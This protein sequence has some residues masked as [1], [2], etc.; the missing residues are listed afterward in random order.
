MKIK[1]IEYENFRNFKDYG[2]IDC[3]VDG[4]ITIIY[5]KNGDGKTT[6][7]QLMK[8]VFYGTVSF[9]R[10]TTDKLYNH[11]F[12]R[13]LRY[14][15]LFEVMGCVD[16]EHNGK[17]YSARRTV[18]Y[19]KE[20]SSSS[21]KK[22]DFVVSYMNDDNDWLRCD[23]PKEV[24][25]KLLP[26][27][28]SDYFFFDGENMIADLKIK[29]SESA[30]KLKTALF[31]IFDLDVLE[32]A[33]A[34]LGR[35]DLKST[36]LGK[37]YLSKGDTQK[38]SDLDVLRKELEKELSELE[39]NKKDIQDITNQEKDND[40]RI[41]EISEEIGS[42]KSKAEYEGKRKEYK[43]HIEVYTQNMI[44]AQASFGD[45]IND[46]FP[47][48]LISKS[49]EQAKRKIRLKV[50]ESKPHVGLNVRLVEYL[51]EDE[52]S[53]CICGNPLCHKEK[54]HIEQL[55][56]LLPPKSYSSMYSEFTERAKNFSKY[57][58]TNKIKGYLVE[59]IRNNEQIVETEKQI[60][61]LDKE[62][63]SCSNIEHL[64][65]ERIERESLKKKLEEDHRTLS[66]NHVVYE[67]KYKKLQKKF[68]EMTAD[69]V[70]AQKVQK[71]IDIIS[72]VID[73]FKTKLDV[74]TSEF[75]QQL[76]NNIQEMINA[77]L[78]S[79]RK[80]NVSKDF[81]VRITDSYNDE[82]K[83]EG[84]FAVVS[85]AYIGGI[86][87]LLQNQD[88]FKDKEYPLV[89]DGPFSKLDNNQRNN[90]IN[91]LPQIAP[92]IILFSKDDLSDVIPENAI[93]K[94]WTIKSNEEKN[95]ASIKEGFL[96]K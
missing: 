22:E 34:D 27:G 49:I 93:G 28:L 77:M 55:L 71:K 72:R 62:E 1:S 54:K 41:I 12:E 10:T 36:V 37:L 33:I 6:L 19:Q 21:W 95:I 87:K 61:L 75:S 59:A 86:F 9:N 50:D 25:E 63:K 70:L 73:Y 76:Q 3:S 5:G 43:K 39:Q 78:T 7:H 45:A 29:G 57:L 47:L 52:V 53:E 15:E 92:Q 44:S 30:S 68:D 24:I 82:S 2:K 81:A 64:Y 80:V 84:Q 18:T 14:A 67:V 26:Q 35:T 83:S 89:L 51:L 17:S 32:N 48:L 23:R 56:N 60:Q 96:W 65:D 20:L 79:Q 4:K 74:E 8:W 69:S 58:D 91:T 16:F 88:R 31:T 13:K 11:E 46:V 66:T 90:V 38:G 94:T 40:K 85:F 42:K